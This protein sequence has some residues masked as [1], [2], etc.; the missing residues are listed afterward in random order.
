M[1]TYQ[2]SNRAKQKTSLD[3]SL[4]NILLIGN[5][6]NNNQSKVILNPSNIETARQ[7]YGEDNDLFRAYKIAYETTKSPNIYTVNCPM[8]TDFIE[9]IDTIVHYNFDY[10]VP[11]SIYIDDSFINPTNDKKTYFC[12]YYIERLGLVDSLTTLIMTDRPSYLYDSID[13]YLIN[14]RK[15]FKTYTNESMNVLEAHGSNMIFT[16]NNLDGIPFSHVLL[17]A[18][19]SIN[20]YTKYP[21]SV[22]YRTH[23]DI[24]DFDI[25]NPNISYFRY[26][27]NYNSCIIENLKN[28]RVVDDIYKWVMV[29]ETIKH[30]IRTLDLEEYRGRLYSPYVKLQINT[31]IKKIME[32]MT[33][34][35]FKQ[36]TIK[37]IQFIKTA[38]AVGYISIELSIVPFGT[39]ENIHI[40][41]GV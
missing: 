22:P 41:M 39:L 13:D 32:E 10:I 35:V 11:I 27:E 18:L 16:L 9:I 6:N 4:K 36:Y 25:N 30:V 1:S 31:R 23:F 3:K 2:I 29:D 28:L 7:M 8:T 20:P 19:L 24:D 5:S 37:N 17:A 34:V 38:P 26:C 15:M 21:D 14:T 33:D 12:N 40:V